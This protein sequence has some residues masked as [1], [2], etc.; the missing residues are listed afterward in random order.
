MTEI[1]L[2]NIYLALLLP[3]WIFLIIMVGR[4]VSVYVNKTIIC[5]LTL[6]AS[7]FGIICT[8]G[9]LWKLPAECVLNTEF[10]FLKINDFVINCGLHADRLSLIFALVLFLVSFFVQIFSIS[11]MKEEKKTYRFYA[12]MN[13]FNFSMA[14]LFFSPN[15][16]QAYFFWEITSVVSYLLIGFEYNK[17]NKSTASKKVFLINRIGDTALI[18]AIIICSY[19]IYAYAPNKNLVTLSFMDMNTISTLVYAYASTPLFEIICGMFIISALVKSAQF[20]FY[21][22]L[23]DAMEAKLPVS[24]LL[25]SATLVAL[26]VFLT[27]RLLSFYSLEPFFLKAIAIF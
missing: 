26:G 22:W 20:P 9:A 13:L 2:D 21:N 25:H 5:I 1:F 23:Q 19:L 18:G 14:S 3:C 15:L 16:F 12:L 24:A 11:Y 10:P 4:F 8:T 6:L 27:L 7:L 17:N